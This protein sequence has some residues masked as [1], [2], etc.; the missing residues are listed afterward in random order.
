MGAHAF[1][2]I[3]SGLA[4]RCSF[5]AYF[6]LGGLRPRIGEA[7]HRL[8][9]LDHLLGAPDDPDRLAAPFDHRE[10]AGREARNVGFHWRA[11]RAARSDGNMLA[12][13]GTAAATLAT[14]PAT[15]VATTRCAAFC[16]LFISAFMDM[17]ER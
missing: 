1:I 15:E 17:E 4:E 14:P 7:R 10:L 11:S 8:Q 12:T 9:R 5:S 2:T 16:P 13:N 3:S 6:G